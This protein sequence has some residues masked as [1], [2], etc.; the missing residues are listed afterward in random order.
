MSVK[1]KITFFD[2]LISKILCSPI[3]CITYNGGVID[4]EFWLAFGST[5]L[6]YFLTAEAYSI[7][8]GSILVLVFKNRPD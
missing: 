2:K 6:F 7:V 4:G 3:S 8:F 1:N 5:V